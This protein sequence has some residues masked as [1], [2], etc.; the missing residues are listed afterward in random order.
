MDFRR[1]YLAFGFA[2]SV[3]VT[4]AQQITRLEPVVVNGTDTL[5]MAFAGGLDAPQLSICDLDRDGTQDLF[6]FD[7]VGDVIIPLVYKGDGPGLN[8]EIDWSLVDNF[9][10]LQ[11]WVLLRDFNGDGVEDIFAATQEPGIQGVDVHRG[12][13]EEGA[14]KFERMTFDLGSFD[15]LYVE[16]GGNYTPLYSSWIDVPSIVDVDGDGDLDFLTFEPGGTYM[17]FQKN[18]AVEDGLGLD[19]FKFDIADICWGKFKEDE[20]SEEL[21]LS[22]DPNKC[23][24]MNIPNIQLRHSGSAEFAYD[25][26][27]DGDLDLLLGDLASSRIVYLENGGT[28]AKAHMTDQVSRFPDNTFAVDLPY[29]VSPFVMDIDHDGK[30]EFL[31]AANSESFTENYNVLWLYDDIGEPGAPDFNFTRDDVFVSEMLDFGSEARPATMDVDADGL[32][33]VIVGTGGYYDEGLR[34]PRL[35]YLRNIGTA[36]SPSFAIADEDFLGFSSFASLPSSNFAPEAGDLDGDGDIDLIVGELNGSLFYLENSAGPGNPVMFG[37]PV[38]PFKDIDVGG[39]ATP[40]LVDLNS[41]GL[42]DIVVGERLGNNDNSGRC[43]NLNYFQNVGSSGAP[44]FGSDP[45][46]SPNTQ[47]LGRVLF[48]PISATTEFSSPDFYRTDGELHMMTGSDGGELLV[49]NNVQNNLDEAFDLLD[50]KYGAIRDGFRSVPELRDMDGDGYFEMIVGNARGGLTMYDT[51]IERDASSDDSPKESNALFNIWPNPSSGKV[52]ISAPVND[53]NYT[54]RVFDVL[55]R[56]VLSAGAVQHLDM[57]NLSAGTY[58]LQFHS[59][60]KTETL[61]VLIT[62]AK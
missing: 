11:L 32:I 35:I 46:V 10:D 33:D 55:G 2:M 20:F 57:G 12:R 49:F 61:P 62:G 60:I 45:T 50:L 9:P 22:P 26:D 21:E 52:Y 18:L 58:I 25:F 8:Y 53:L 27:K 17:P 34:D 6:V 39:Y 36:D 47:C 41:D 15:V 31:A 42:L 40:A 56:E 30:D 24:G 14:L 7:R 3:L 51:D 37:T 13:I 48:N 5:E 43:S 4:N 28:A 16:V 59:G 54:I 38:Y 44:D 1:C 19:T 29:F 23:A